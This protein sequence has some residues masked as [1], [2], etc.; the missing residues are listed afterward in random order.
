MIRNQDGL[1]ALR[2]FTSNPATIK[3]EADKTLYSFV[4]RL[5]VSLAWV[6]PEHVPTLL[7]TQ[8]KI[9][10]GKQ[11]NKFR[12]ANSMDVSLWETGTRPTPE[13]LSKY[14]IT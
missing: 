10:C 5:S 2:H 9:C 1:V 11:A 12:F 13:F 4:P 7:Q 8:A 3:M 6:R 14:S